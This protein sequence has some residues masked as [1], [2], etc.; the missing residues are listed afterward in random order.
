MNVNIFV[1][2]KLNF[3][4]NKFLVLLVMKVRV[5][6]R[7]HLRVSDTISTRDVPYNMINF[8]NAVVRYI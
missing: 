3:S 1:E 2:K 4:L 8:T 7:R 6:I 5:G